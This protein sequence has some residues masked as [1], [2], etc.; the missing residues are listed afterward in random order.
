MDVDDEGIPLNKQDLPYGGDLQLAFRSRAKQADI[1][2][3]VKW[4]NKYGRYQP[5]LKEEV[6][7]IKELRICNN[8]IDYISQDPWDENL[9]P[10]FFISYMN[11]D[12]TMS[13]TFC[14]VK[15]DIAKLEHYPEFILAAWIPLHPSFKLD[16]NG[17]VA[18]V[19]YKYA[20]HSSI[21]EFFIRIPEN[22]LILYSS[23]IKALTEGDAFIA[24]PI[25]RTRVGNINSSF[26]SSSAHGQLPEEIIYWLVRK[27]DF[28][29]KEIYS[30]IY[31]QVY[32]LK[33]NDETDNGKRTLRDLPQLHLTYPIAKADIDF[34][35][36]GERWPELNNIYNLDQYIPKYVKGMYVAENIPYTEH[37]I[38]DVLTPIII[39][40]PNNVTLESELLQLE[41]PDAKRALKGHIMAA[42]YKIYMDRNVLLAYISSY[43]GKVCS[44]KFVDYDEASLTPRSLYDVFD[45]IDLIVST[46][47]YAKGN[48]K[49][50]EKLNLPDD[51]EMDT[52]FI[53]DIEETIKELSSPYKIFGNIL[54]LIDFMFGEA[55][56]FHIGAKTNTS[57]GPYFAFSNMYGWNNTTIGDMSPIV[58]L[59]FS[60]QFY[61]Y[62]TEQPDNINYVT[63][64]SWKNYEEFA[65]GA[66][67]YLT[68]LVEAIMSNSDILKGFLFQKRNAD[69][70]VKVGTVIDQFIL[71]VL[72]ALHVLAHED[73]SILLRDDSFSGFATQNKIS[74]YIDNGYTIL[75]SN[76][77]SEPVLTNI[78]LSNKELYFT[79]RIL[80]DLCPVQSRI[81]NN[82][83]DALIKLSEQGL[84]PRFRITSNGF[85]VYDEYEESILSSDDI[86]DLDSETVYIL[87]L[88]N[89]NFVRLLKET[90]EIKDY[91]MPLQII[92]VLSEMLNPDME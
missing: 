53:G 56:S 55:F 68:N 45:N 24:V 41:H 77:I 59:I 28:G 35:W 73:I 64:V 19:D 51:L 71:V 75:D 32:R 85:Y 4:N 7:S 11:E 37:I 17:Y 21:I 30:E 46:W 89:P 66:M 90:G 9:Q 38:L 70:L 60:S 62:N 43:K 88:T 69:N 8:G 79:L 72:R 27:E 54:C 13:P 47:Y 10:N 67:K 33:R 58:E 15:E 12:G 65:G 26:L 48:I 23:Y 39:E 2:L 16:E 6:P 40:I 5:P 82:I 42:L 50:I 52:S 83:F 61:L 87:Y 14:Y 29:H 31:K 76:V 22:R 63:I 81:I 18:D 91:I 20:V 78:I 74:D 3:I 80:S 92:N 44:A 25:Y 36:N 1:R 49:E 84:S 34:M 86:N 57:R